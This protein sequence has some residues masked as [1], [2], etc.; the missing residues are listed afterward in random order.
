MYVSV[1]GLKETSKDIIFL[2]VEHFFYFPLM[3]L[4]L[5]RFYG[6]ACAYGTLQT[7]VLLLSLPEEFPPCVRVHFVTRRLNFSPQAAP[8]GRC[9]G[10]LGVHVPKAQGL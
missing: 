9:G 5:W 4:F 10:N 1:T 8:G 3:T 6:F 7:F 2:S